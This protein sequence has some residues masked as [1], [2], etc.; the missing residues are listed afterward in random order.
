MRTI[1]LAIIAALAAGTTAAPAFAKHHH[2]AS[3][4]RYD[5]RYDNC[6]AGKSRAARRGTVIGAAAGGA[7]TAILGGDVGTSLLGA[8]VGAVAGHEIGRN[9]HRC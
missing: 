2:K 1:S 9:G 5:S 6:R 8:G 3:Y 4:Q 7:G